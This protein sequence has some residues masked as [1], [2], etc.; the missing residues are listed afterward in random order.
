[1]LLRFRILL[2]IL[3][4]AACA[5]MP[6]SPGAP[7]AGRGVPGDSVRADLSLLRDAVAAYHPGLA[8]YGQSA[9]FER[10][11]DSLDAALASRTKPVPEGEAVLL[12]ASALHVLADGHTEV[13]PID[14]DPALRERLWG[15]RSVLPFAFRITRGEGGEHRLV[16]TSDLT[17]ALQPGTEIAEIDG[18]PVGVILD[19]L[20]PYTSGDG[21]GT[22]ALRLARLGV[23]AGAFDWLARSSFDAFYPL[24]YPD[25]PQRATLVVRRPGTA[26]WTSAV[27]GR[28]TRAEREERADAA[29]ASVPTGEASWS[30]RMVGPEAALVRLGTFATWGFKTP[31]DTLLADI[32]RDLKRRGI[33][34]LILDV[35]GVPGGNL[36]ALSVARYLTTGPVAC[37]GDATVIADREPD[38]SFFPYLEAY[39]GGDGW[40]TPLPDAAVEPLADGRYRLLAGPPCATPPVPAEAF[41]GPVAVLADEWNE[42]ATFTLLRVVR[43]QALGTIVGRPAGGNLRGLTAG[44][45]LRLRLPRT[46]LVVTLPL[47]SSVPEGAPTDGPLVPDV[48][49]EWTAEDVAAGRDPDVEAA[50][51]AL[52]AR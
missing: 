12:V 10:H 17:G 21:L 13:T 2:A 1:M 20:L 43:E 4:T 22:D 52:G 27:V 34:R 47:L 9:A 15:G 35:R 14:Q 33:G 11:L 41:G 36:G 26:E 42:S 3:S 50:L 37:L 29:G 48:V 5:Q 49:V 23:P 38:P 30:A 25:A 51:S 8:M 19:G 45:V 44:I 16:V 18:R 40:K 39:G 6:L 7:A 31:T 32:F 24:A 28:L 46:G